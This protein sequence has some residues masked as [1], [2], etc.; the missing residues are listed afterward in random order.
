MGRREIHTRRTRLDQTFARM[1][2]SSD[3]PEIQADFAR[4]LIVLTCGFLE[5]SIEAII[6]DFT[7]RRSGGEVASY[8]EQQLKLWTNPN[9]EKIKT[10]LGTFKSSWRDQ[11]EVYLVDEKK[12]SVNGLVA[13]RH[14]I[15]HGDHVGTTLS[16]AKGYYNNIKDVVEF[17]VGIVDPS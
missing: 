8:V 3:D 13:L 16:Q 11:L 15:A 17:I 7:K 9:C 6:L 2:S 4:Y 14:R 10:L 1:P 12:D 5:N